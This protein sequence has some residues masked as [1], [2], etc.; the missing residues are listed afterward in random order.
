MCRTIAQG[1]GGK[2]KQQSNGKHI[3]NISRVDGNIGLL[4]KKAGKVHVKGF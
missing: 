3:V 1:H 4:A 2:E